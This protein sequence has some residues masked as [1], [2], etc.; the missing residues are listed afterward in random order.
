MY[1]KSDPIFRCTTPSTGK[2]L[3]EVVVG[4]LY[5]NSSE[6]AAAFRSFLLSGVR[7]AA[8]AFRSFLRSGVRA[9]VVRPPLSL[10]FFVLA[11]LL[12]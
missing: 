4:T 10:P 5:H 11:Y 8:A 3:G 1:K 12:L 6:L 9:A 2:R 7:A